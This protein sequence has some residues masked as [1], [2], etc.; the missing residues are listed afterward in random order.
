VLVIKK[1]PFIKKRGVINEGLPSDVRKGLPFR[2][3]SLECSEAMPPISNDN[4]LYF[5]TSVTNLR[6]PVFQ[7]DRLKKVLTDAF[8]EARASAEFKLFAYVIMPDHYHVIT[9]NKLKASEVLRYLNGISARRVINYLKD[10]N[11]V[12]SLNKLRKEEGRNGYKY[13]LWEHHSNTFLI[14]TESMMLQKVNYIHL[15]PV[16][17]QLVDEPVDY[18]FSSFRFWS[19]RMRHPQEPLEVDTKELVW[20]ALK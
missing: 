9:D 7:T 16:D 17:E 20:K 3:I 4:P 15:N 13:S 6:L 12:S 5:L 10:N 2:E 8:I 18:L 11:H 1:G 14:T 19:N